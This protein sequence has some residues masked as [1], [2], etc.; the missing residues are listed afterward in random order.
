MKHNKN[1]II[2]LS[3]IIFSCLLF[4]G[5][6]GF[7]IY[8]LII[9]P[10]ISKEVN[11]K[12][13][14]MYYNDSVQD[15]SGTPDSL[16]V[17]LPYRK[18]EVTTST[19]DDY[20]KLDKSSKSGAKDKNGVLLKFSKLISYNSDI[21]GWL[22]IPGTDIDY[23]VMQAYNGSDFY[24]KHDFEGN[25][26]KNGC[27]YIDRNCNVKAPSKN[28]V[29]HGHNMDTTGMM[30]HELPKYRDINFY[31]AHPVFTFDSIYN[32]SKW[33][34][35]AYMRVSG[36]NAQNGDFNYMR[37]SFESKDDFLNFVYQ[38]ELRSL[39]KCPVSVNEK[40]QLL[41]LSTCS[42][43]V[44][45]YRTVVVARKI[46]KNESTEVN[47][48]LASL[49]DE[50]LYPKSWYSKY[51]GKAPLITSFSDALSFNEI[52]WYDGK[53][54]VDAGV[55]KIIDSEDFQYEVTSDSTAKLV[56]YTNK[57]AK[58]IEI[59]SSIKVNE[60]TYEITEIDPDAFLDMKKLKELKIG[61]KITEIK[62]KTFVKCSRLQSVIIGDSVEKIGKRAFFGLKK[63]R[64]VKFRCVNLKSID[65][66]AF[67]DIHPKAKMKLPKTKYKDYMKL[68]KKSVV[69]DKTKY[70]KY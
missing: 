17:T 49:R 50:V 18:S 60:R 56:N 5:C 52:D 13:R 66:K 22:K 67:K 12:Y 42:Y 15:D 44:D 39:Y 23:P 32:E 31:K 48:A 38:I 61:N 28:I 16:N 33:K 1:K 62:P 25:T 6:T 29:I 65:E 8:Y 20:I 41:M 64:K 45:N 43:E 51:G 46:R 30:F 27:L 58:S 7:L 2:R 24:L 68:I 9:Q 54:T 21:K 37:G 59:P 34:I 26:D 36:E 40:D 70:T 4:T 10:H 11:N 3:L 63:L 53:I 57:K 47:T 19:S 69:S 35:I 55:G 14:S